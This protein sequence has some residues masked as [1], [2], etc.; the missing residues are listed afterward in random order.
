MKFFADENVASETVEFLRQRGWDVVDVYEAGL[1]GG[2]DE[3]IVRYAAKEKR[4]ILTHDLD[5]GEMHYFRKEP[6]FGVLV[7]RIEP[8]I[9]TDVNRILGEFLDEVGEDIQGYADTLIIVEKK[10]FRIRQQPRE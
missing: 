4:M 8:Q 2:P 9:P 5:F 10:R 6:V 1:R 3:E 7:L